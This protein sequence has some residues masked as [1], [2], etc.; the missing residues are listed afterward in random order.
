MTTLDQVAVENL[1]VTFL[2]SSG[3]EYT[4]ESIRA[5]IDK[6][7]D[8]FGWGGDSDKERL[9][10]SLEAK[11]T[12][13]MNI[14]VMVTEN[15]QPWLDARKASINPYFWGRYANYLMSSSGF[16]PTVVARLNHVTDKILG[17]LED[18]TRK[19]SWFRRG[20]V[21]GH[22]QSG[23][24]ANYI[25][26]IN[27]AADAGYRLVILIAGTLNNLRKQTQERVDEGFIGRDSSQYLNAKRKDVLVGV[28][29]RE[30]SRFPVTFTNTESDF[31]KS[32]ARILG[33]SPGQVT[34]PVI[35]VVKK[36]TSTLANLLEWMKQHDAGA[37]EARTSE[38]PMLL[39]DDEADYASINTKDD[40]TDPTRTNKLIREILAL[41]RRR[42][43]VGYTA[44][45]FANIFIDPESTDE[46]LGDDL[47]P[48]DFIYSLDP[49]SNYF[50]PV[51]IF[52]DPPELDVVRECDDYESF[53]PLN[54]KIDARPSELPASLLH[55]IRCFVL[56][57][58]IRLAR[59]QVKKHNSMLINVSR[60]TGVQSHVRDLVDV[61]VDKLKDSVRYNYKLKWNRA[62]QNEY[63]R[64][65]RDTWDR[66]YA[67][68]P[69][70]W[71]EI[72][73]LLQEAVAPIVVEEVNV[74]S[75][76]V[77]TLN[78]KRN[79]EHGLNVIAVGGLS[80]SRGFTLEGLS[81]SYLIR[82]TQMYDTLLQMGRWFGY[83]D[84][85]GDVCRLVMP[86]DAI[87][88]YAHITE[89]SEELRDEL[90]RMEA[91]G[92][93]PKDFGLKVRA[94]PDTLIVTARNKMRKAETVYWQVELADRLIETTRVY[95]EP[96]INDLNVA[97]F[98][99]LASA[100]MEKK[101]EPIR[102]LGSYLWQKVDRANVCAFLEEFKNHPA[103][104]N[105][106]TE[107][108]VK[109]CG[110]PNNP[111]L[112]KWDVAFIGIDGDKAPADSFATLGPLRVACQQRR[113]TLMSEMSPR[114]FA[115]SDTKS[116]VASRGAEKL[117][118][119][120]A[121]LDLAKQ[122]YLEEGGSGNNIP[123]RA[124]RAVR[125]RPLLMI[126][127]L[128][129]NSDSKIAAY[130]IS[131]PRSEG[132]RKAVLTRYE[133][134]PIWWNEQFQLEFEEEQEDGGSESEPVA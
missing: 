107:A 106:H 134:N 48:R 66:E 67:A 128:Q 86:R 118:L 1:I 3:S 11:L 7:A 71:E 65:L 6:M 5:A 88:W 55:A 87:G 13:R 79:K 112:E 126:H 47:F 44:T 35:L 105:T 36:N 115:I 23:K 117:G 76:G 57:K 82:N 133:V 123:D 100:L 127:L 61:Y 64:A 92:L 39:I 102:K 73:P 52:S 60:F 83:R 131:F 27:K 21:M 49:P 26:L 120:E 33:I 68:L 40:D 101:G 97:S 14:G 4:R 95:A 63:I 24:T 111:K 93:T 16:A 8:I 2:E 103:S 99:A 17:T 31:R 132:N 104:L 124:Y 20:L 130:G 129:A 29:L 32:T 72:Q 77:G 70:T 110:D 58:A 116:R 22:V 109:Y 74:K 42:C 46:M 28:G 9:Q 89:A 114:A 12:I 56:I 53:L 125:E 25:G 108:V 50:G 80:L 90:K 78:Y 43:Y 75:S 96:R 94:H 81:M 84:G 18:P 121:Q 62:S 122:K 10:K 19:G 113:V 54:H 85:Y 38:M 30:S 15:F 98:G 51:G 69:E 91:A 119:T 41:F 45:P 34:V 59:G 37:G